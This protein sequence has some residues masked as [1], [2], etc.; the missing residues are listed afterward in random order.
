VRFLDKQPADLNDAQLAELQ[1]HFKLGPGGNAEIARSWLALVVR[2]AYEPAYADLERFLLSTGRHKLVV[3]L[4]RDLARSE[5]GLE[6]GRRIYSKAK[7]GYHAS[8][9]QAVERLLD[10]AGT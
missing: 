2:S 10:P 9:R 8:I 1:T 3:G 6:L 5:P 7:S 4:Y